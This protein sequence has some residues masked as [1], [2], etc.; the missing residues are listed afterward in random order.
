MVGKGSPDCSESS[1]RPVSP[2]SEAMISSRSSARSTDCTPGSATSTSPSDRQTC[3]STEPA[4]HRVEDVSGSGAG[5]SPATL[6]S[7]PEM[8]RGG[9]VGRCCDCLYP[10]REWLSGGVLLSHTR[11]EGST[12][13]AGGLSFRV[14]NGTGRFPA[15][16]TAVTSMELSPSTP[17]TIHPRLVLLRGVCAGWWCPF[18]G[19]EPYS[20]RLIFS[21]TAAHQHLRAG[22]V[23]VCGQVLGLLVPVSCT[24]YCASTSGLST[25]WSAGGLTHVNRGGRPHLETG[26]PLRCFQRLSLP[27]VANQPCPWR[28][29]WH[30]RGSSVPVLSY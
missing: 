10:C 19:R 2:S 5:G 6:G 30:T 20:G 14:R 21:F 9:G 27:N 16:M 8:P 28:N 25:Q 11:S 3:R 26:F 12:I 24:H 7:V 1:L 29:N 18:V 22:W 23:S 13:G 17:R 4:F 15:A